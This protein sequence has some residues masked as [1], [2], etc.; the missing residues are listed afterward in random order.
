Y[1]VEDYFFYEIEKPVPTELST[2]V[3]AGSLDENGVGNF[4]IKHSTPVESPEFYYSSFWFEDKIVRGMRYPRI[5]KITNSSGKDV[6]SWFNLDNTYYYYARATAKPSTLKNPA[7]Y[8]ETFTMHVTTEVDIDG[9]NWYMSAMYDASTYRIQNTAKSGNNGFTRESK[10]VDPITPNDP[11]D[12]NDPVS[13]FKFVNIRHINED[14]GEVL[15]GKF[16]MYLSSSTVTEEAIY[17]RS[18]ERRVG[19]VYSE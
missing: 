17:D 18:E 2:P 3:K 19:K 16:K 9:I 13:I 7:F 1:P 11:N 14:N 5:Q 8:G 10:T 6:T 12:P 15:E 4:T